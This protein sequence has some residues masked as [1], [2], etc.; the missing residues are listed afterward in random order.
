METFFQLAALALVVTAGPAVIVL[1][2]ASKGNLLLLFMNI[3][4]NQIFVALFVAFFT[5]VLALR[6]GVELY[7]L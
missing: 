6:L 5:G 4:D 2:A 3:A 7:K 1:L